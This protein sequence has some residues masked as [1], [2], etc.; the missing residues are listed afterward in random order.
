MEK[1][2]IERF[3]SIRTS[4]VLFFSLVFLSMASTIPTHWLGQAPNW[5][6]AAARVMGADATFRSPLFLALLLAMSLNVTLCT[7]HRVASRLRSADRVRRRIAWLDACVHLSLILVL[8]GGGGKALFGSVGTGYL[9][10]GVTVTS[11]SDPLSGR[12]FPLGF[13]VVLR[14]RR[15]EYYPLRLRLGVRERATG[16]KL[17]QFELAEGT[18]GRAV[19]SGSPVAVRLLSTDGANVLLDVSS[20]AGAEKM[21]LSLSSDAGATATH[22]PYELVVIAYRR[23]LR[24]V[25]G[26]IA[27][28][29]G[30]RVVREAWLEV[31]GGVSYRGTQ[32]FLTVWGA[33]QFG[34][35]FLGI[36]YSRDPLAPVFW[37]G[38]VLLAVLLPF[39]LMLRHRRIPGSEAAELRERQPPL[40]VD[41]DHQA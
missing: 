5:L 23:D 30:G 14:E 12:E 29:E 10:P 25:G 32:F 3:R 16:R 41:A 2:V 28:L 39:F 35:Q 26:R 1:G 24:A 31:N 13:S 6:R 27:I 11:F 33:D 9:F 18:P 22:G 34:N 7:F 21:Q 8:I 36:Q 4:L 38:A 40:C 17:D 20:A 15:E 37:A 19:A